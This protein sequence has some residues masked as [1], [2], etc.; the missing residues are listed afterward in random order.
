MIGEDGGD[1]G[2]G[3]DAGKPLLAHIDNC[4]Q[5]SFFIVKLGHFVPLISI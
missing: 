5:L 1:G 2:D 3:G 4:C